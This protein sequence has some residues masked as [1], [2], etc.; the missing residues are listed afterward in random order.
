MNPIVVIE[1]NKGTMKAEIFI[2]KVPETGENFL[3]LVRKGFYN[4][5]KFHRVIKDFMIQGG[6][7]N[8]DGTGGPGYQIK[9][10]FVPSLRHDTKG[11][12]SMANAGPNT[13]GSQF[14]ITLA[15]TPWLDDHHSVFGRLTDGVEVLDGI[16]S[17]AVG[18]NDAPLEPVIMTKVFVE[19]E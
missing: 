3:A 17:V 15:P 8:G 10:E 2:D 14:F 4:G 16:G 11:V 18:A 7:P 12:L 19:G 13:G 5:L 1:T 9:D 6:D